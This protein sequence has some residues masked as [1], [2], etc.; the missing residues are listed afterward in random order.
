MGK[1]KLIGKPSRADE[2]A[3]LANSNSECKRP[4]SATGMKQL[5]LSYREE[6][7]R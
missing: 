5:Y 3:H 4:S 2:G 7:R 6:W 1:G